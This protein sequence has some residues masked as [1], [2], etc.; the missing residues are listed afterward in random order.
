M[1]LILPVLAAAAVVLIVARLLVIA[2]DI[3]DRYMEVGQ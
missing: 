1:I 2:A 3:R